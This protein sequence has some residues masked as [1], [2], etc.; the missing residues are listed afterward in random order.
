MLSSG[1]NC[2]SCSNQSYVTRI[3]VINNLG[4]LLTLAPAPDKPL[5]NEAPL[6][7]A[8]APPASSAQL[9]TEVT[10]EPE[11]VPVTAPLAHKLPQLPSLP[12][13]QEDLEVDVSSWCR[14]YEDLLRE[15]GQERS[16][17]HQDLLRGHSFMINMI[18][19]GIGMGSFE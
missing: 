14:V 10:S 4:W 18:I 15:Y 11:N 16:H 1:N 12:E 13:P 9:V 6:V 8:P 7:P 19:M 3:G 5:G 2:P 17:L